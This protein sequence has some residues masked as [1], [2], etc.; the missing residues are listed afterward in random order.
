MLNRKL[1]RECVHLRGQIISIAAVVACGI[2]SVVLMRGTYESLVISQQSYYRDYLLADVWAGLK[3]AP[4]TVRPRIE[5]IPGVARVETRVTLLALL[6]IEGRQEPARGQFISLPRA[7][8]ES[9][10]RLHLTRG[11]YVAPGTRDEA[12]ISEGFALA[13]DLKPGDSLDAIING[14]LRTLAIVGV[15]I[16]PEHVYEVPAG[17]LYPDHERY[18]IVWMSRAVLG[19][20]YDMDGAF[21]EVTLTLAPGAN[22]QEVIDGLDRLLE[23][24]GGL[25]AFGRENRPS[26]EIV[27]D[28][29]AQNRTSGTVLPA[30]FLAV[31]AF[32]LHI[33]LGR[34]IATQ[35]TEIAVLK[36][37]GYSNRQVGKHYLGFA[38]VAVAL[39]ALV[40]SGTG[41]WLGNGMVRL[42]GDFFRFPELAYYVKWPLFAIG[43]AVS[44]LAAGI[45]ALAAVRGAVELPP[46][47]AMRPEPPARF[48]PGWIERIGLGAGMSA[49]ARMILRNVERQPVR[50]MLSAVGVA[51][52]VAILVIGLFM[53]DGVRFMM[54]LTF[55][56]IQREDLTILFHEPRGAAIE[57]ELGRLDG[58]LRIEPFRAVP[59]RFRSRHLEHEGAITG[60]AAGTKLRRIVTTRGREHPLPPEG[61]LLSQA[62][63]DKLGVAAGGELFVEVL[64]GERRTGSIRVAGTV[65]EP[66]GLSAYMELD[67]LTAFARGGDVISGAYLRVESDRLG[68]LNQR[69]KELPVISGT[70][71]RA[72]QS[73]SFDE[74][75]AEGLL[76]GLTAL[77]GFAGVIAVGVVYNGARISL[78][79][80]GRE[81]ASLRVLGFRRR[82]VAVLLLGEQALIT[83][84]AIPLGWLLGYL[85]SAAISTALQSESYRIP[86]VIT[87]ATYLWA[88]LA[89]V[90]AAVLSGL[91]VRRRL[92]RMDLVTVLKTRE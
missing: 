42:Y 62:L 83:L 84:L 71:S 14:R 60:F 24:Y 39:G 74:R 30:V 44:A 52:S 63:A 4:E 3:R 33:V 55:R 46:A 45:G 16:S 64:E 61:V 2:M 9:L 80:R 7:G 59:V 53:F 38:V 73:A 35:R 56:Q 77:L 68:A 92:D 34:L 48:K 40:G 58:V 66:M 91:L 57:Y 82:E 90:I 29:L 87:T 37:F 50:S 89:V 69:L 36:A 15:A 88:G 76:I 13:N 12:I 1:V 81:L 27:E 43:F 23:R 85:L 79:E 65:D 11:R 49:S 75:L 20:A 67:A 19:P 21:N 8:R 6:D 70:A 5:R 54:D 86:L 22:E 17:A 28:E 31:A 25:G 78:S 10:N 26:L 32:L 51:F 18:G 72:A 41:I 47:E